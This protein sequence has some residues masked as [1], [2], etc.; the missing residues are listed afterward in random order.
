M[1]MKLWQESNS[2]CGQ[3]SLVIS[4]LNEKR[5]GYYL[6]IGA[7]HFK[8]SSNTFLLE[9]KLDWVGIAVEISGKYSRKYNR[10]RKNQCIKSDALLLNYKNLLVAGNFPSIV[11]YLQL[12][13]DPSINTFNCL[14]K[15]PFEQ[16]QFRV[17]TFEHDLYVSPQNKIYQDLGHS[18]LESFG[19]VRIAKNV[20]YNGLAF[21]DWY[22]HPSLVPSEATKELKE[23]VDWQLHF[24]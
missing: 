2:Q 22:V 16:F 9:S 18:Y 4:I 13:I 5:N 3:E 19:Y 15:I 12:D 11:D 7:W 21:E 10:N 6:E 14:L 20:R 17:I 8:D 24:D 23:N 1:S